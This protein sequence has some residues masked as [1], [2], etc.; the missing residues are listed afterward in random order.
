MVHYQIPRHMDEKNELQVQELCW[1]S[2][3]QAAEG[4]RISTL[5]ACLW[6]KSSL[7]V[8]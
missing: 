5:G 1:D 8:Q 4:M 2:S 3:Q 6:L 7:H